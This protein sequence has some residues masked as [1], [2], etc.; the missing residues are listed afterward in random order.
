MNSSSATLIPASPPPA[1]PIFPPSPSAWKTSYMSHIYTVCENAEGFMLMPGWCFTFCRALTEWL[2]LLLQVRCP[3]QQEKWCADRYHLMVRCSTSVQLAVTFQLP[4]LIPTCVC[5]WDERC[6]SKHA[7][8]YNLKQID[9]SLS[10]WLRHH[11][12][13][14]SS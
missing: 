12:S 1:A 6:L 11:F 2:P 8:M 7:M 10:A 5:V 4:T 9:Q 14:S 13:L 3:C